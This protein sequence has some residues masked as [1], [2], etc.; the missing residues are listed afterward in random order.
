ML[1]VKCE[2][3]KNFVLE[4]LLVHRKMLIKTNL[5]I[6]L[7][8]Y[9]LNLSKYTSYILHVSVTAMWNQTLK[10]D[11]KRYSSYLQQATHM[12]ETSSPTKY[13]VI[14]S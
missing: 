1:Q 9:F 14:Q 13:R 4:I 7:D 5:Y 12:T 8:I 11:V 2:C 3:F 10:S 6:R